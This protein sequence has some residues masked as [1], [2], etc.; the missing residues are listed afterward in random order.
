M[1]KLIAYTFIIFF[2]SQCS[3]MNENYTKINRLEYLNKLEGFWL[4]QCIANWTGLIT[5]MDKIGIPINGKGGGF[6]TRED[7]GKPDQPNLW[8]SNELSKTI[9]YIYAEK[10]S[11]WGAD[12]DTD[13]EYIYQELLLNSPSLDLTGE[14]IRNAWINHIH[15]DEEN[16]LWVSNQ[17]A[18]DLM[19]NGVIPPETSNP[20]LNPHYEMI[21]A[22]LTTE[23]FGFFAPT[24]PEIAMA[25]GYLPVRTTARDNAAWISEFNIIMYSLAS[26]K[27]EHKTRK[28]KVIWMAKQARLHLP[29]DSYSAKMFDFVLEQYNQNILWEDARNALHQKYQI[30]QE[31][32]YHWATT[33]KSCNGCFAAGIN[34]GASIISLLYGEGDIKETIKIGALAGWDSDNPTA[35]WGGLLGFMLG[36]NEVEKIFDKELSSSFNIHRTRKGFPNQGIDNFENMALKGQLIVDRVVQ[37]KMGG[38]IDHQNDIWIIPNTENE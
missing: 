27:T 6:Y 32:G 16:F 20:D 30:R 2:F 13:I 28:E 22:Q 26:I 21:D 38:E 37:E 19:N 1:K 29:N 11:I 18:F 15:L 4:G 34:F 33:D 31:D 24:K 36:K 25:L 8:G 9:N 7:W 14:Q 17:K 10:D 3:K 12:D 35:T 5:E 23:I